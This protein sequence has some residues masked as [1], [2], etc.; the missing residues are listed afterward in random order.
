[1]GRVRGCHSFILSFAF[2]IFESHSFSNPLILE[3]FTLLE[4][5]PLCNSTLHF[6]AIKNHALSPSLYM[7]SP[8]NSKL[9]CIR[10]LHVISLRIRSF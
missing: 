1:M 6:F 5:A 7:E 9:H 10:Q 4:C 2:N 3:S 8:L